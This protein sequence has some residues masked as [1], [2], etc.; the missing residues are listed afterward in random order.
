MSSDPQARAPAIRAPTWFSARHLFALTRRARPQP[1]AALAVVAVPDLPSDVMPR[2][3]SWLAGD[4][5]TL[6]A[7]AC[8]SR[9]W[10]DL[11]ASPALW[12]ALLV[13]GAAARAA[14]TPRRLASLL[15]RAGGLP[16]TA[17]DLTA[18]VN[19]TGADVLAALQGRALALDRLCLSGLHAQ[20][21]G[22]NWWNR[23]GYAVS[24]QLFAL[25]AAPKLAA[26]A[27]SDEEEVYS[28]DEAGSEDEAVGPWN[29][30]DED[31]EEELNP[32][33]QLFYQRR[34]AV[35]D[36][37]GGACGRLCSA[38]DAV[39]DACC[40][41]C[42]G[43]AYA[44]ALCTEGTPPGVAPQLALLTGVVNIGVQVCHSCWVQ[45]DYRCGVPGC[46][47]ALTYYYWDD[48]RPQCSGCGS[49]M[50]GL[51]YADAWLSDD[52]DDS[53]DG[54]SS[55]RLCAS[56]AARMAV[57]EP[58]RLT[59]CSVCARRLYRHAE[60]DYQY[61]SRG[62]R[63][64]YLAE[65]H[66]ERLHDAL[67]RPAQRPTAAMVVVDTSVAAG[68]PSA[69]CLACRPEHVRRMAVAARAAEHQAAV[70]A[71][72]ARDDT[73]LELPPPAAA[74]GARTGSR[75]AERRRASGG[76]CGG[77]SG[78][79]A[80]RSAP[81]HMRG[82]ARRQRRQ[83]EPKQ[84]LSARLRGEMQ[85]Q[86]EALDCLQQGGHYYVGGGDASGTHPPQQPT[87]AAVGIECR[88]LST[89]AQA[90]QMAA[91]ERVCDDACSLEL[92]PP[93][94]AAGVRAGDRRAARRRADMTR[95]GRVPMPAAR[96]AGSSAPP[97]LWGRKR[98]PQQPRSRA[99]E[100][101]ARE[102][103]LKLGARLRDE[104]RLQLEAL[105]I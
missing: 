25:T 78:A 17:L 44:C 98:E 63:G 18:C 16:L 34:C 11:A 35:A 61:S 83:R 76:A 65:M 37:F 30:T 7:A 9:Q 12:T 45:E 32:E 72:R 84:K 95:C 81:K 97:L 67:H 36:A 69:S 29:S 49:I 89:Q 85:L 59:S 75:R 100:R 52:S 28:S 24:N 96:S 47:V 91:S 10:R 14:L 101:R 43:T 90:A 79:A 15:D 86:L 87:E 66:V 13:H 71:E 23:H 31:V 53:K 33:Q 74:A 73:H 102:S 50:C 38:A 55:T 20:P 99:R 62:L 94:S 51:C 21:P 88:A 40:R 42:S 3:F 41:V 77:S 57:K 39:P 92:P 104:L 80:Q 6:C 58:A 70:A 64:F 60:E 27:G 26:E 4:V 22:N 68:L 5:A 46:H 1:D 105:A 56:C 93:A 48:F 103:K 19:L 8:V 82:A 2:L 54:F